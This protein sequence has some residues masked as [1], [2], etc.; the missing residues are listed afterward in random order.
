MNNIYI[1]S[2]DD[3]SHFT[4]N[5]DDIPAIHPE[6]SEAV[7]K[8]VEQ[9]NE[10]VRQKGP[11]KFFKFTQIFVSVAFFALAV[12]FLIIQEKETVLRLLPVMLI[13]LVT[14][15]AMKCA[16]EAMK[17][18]ARDGLKSLIKETEPTMVRF[19]GIFIHVPEDENRYLTCNNKRVAFKLMA[20]F[21]PFKQNLLN[22]VVTPASKELIDI[23][24]SIH[25]N[26]DRVE[27]GQAKDLHQ[28]LF[29]ADPPEADHEGQP[30]IGNGV[31]LAGG[32]NQ[33]H[34]EP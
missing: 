2:N 17:M 24:D 34:L 21:R 6:C 26:N 8:F 18:K 30:T 1:Y 25:E 27:I 12:P 32:Q 4:I 10:V 33:G 11:S 22:K 23:K 29:V 19:Y 9:A 15:Y 3:Y 5:P 13:L 31:D 14:H 20:K 16:R 7:H 28:P